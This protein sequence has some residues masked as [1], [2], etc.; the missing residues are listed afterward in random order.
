MFKIISTLSFLFLSSVGF[1]FT[2][3]EIPGPPDEKPS[4]YAPEPYQPKEGEPLPIGKKFYP[5][6]TSRDLF[7]EL[8]PL[9]LVRRGLEFDFE[10]RVGENI[11]FGSDIIYTN[12]EIYSE[13]GTTGKTSYLGLGPK[14]RFYPMNTLSGLFFGGKI[15]LGKTTSLI[16][17]SNRV[18]EFTKAQISPTVQIGY[19][20]S[21]F[22]KFAMAAYL[23]GGF[24]IPQAAIAE[25][26]SE[27]DQWNSA[28]KKLNDTNSL[29]KP[30][31]GITIGVGI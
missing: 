8:N 13:A 1:A 7:L 31:F 26:T 15:Y 4:P 9:L 22:G 27:N 5:A 29:F 10:M 25:D 17:Q 11:S 16:E 28:R 6:E 21:Q 2:E 20:F 12:A 24:N 30:D 18:S 19:R 14:I 3:E 23:G